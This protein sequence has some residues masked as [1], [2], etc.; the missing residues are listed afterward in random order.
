MPWGVY[1]R[2]P[3]ELLIAEYDMERMDFIREGSKVMGPPKPVVVS[4]ED[5]PLDG[6][7]R[8]FDIAPDV[9]YIHGKDQYWYVPYLNETTTYVWLKMDY[10]RWGRA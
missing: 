9:M 4:F 8:Q 1:P 3:M 7:S 5:G 6:R 10:Y 2:D